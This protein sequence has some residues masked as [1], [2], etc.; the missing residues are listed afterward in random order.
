[1]DVNN[2]H[3]LNGIPEIWDKE[4]SNMS[5]TM[6]LT[7]NKNVSVTLYRGEDDNARITDMVVNGAKAED[8]EYIVLK[9][10]LR[11]EIG[12]GAPQFFPGAV[13]EGD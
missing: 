4:A 7:N 11:K 6:T 5:T 1:M 12:E 2:P 8:A 13:K 9:N 3:T 10:R